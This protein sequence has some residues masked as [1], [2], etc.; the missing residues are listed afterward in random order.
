MA[1]SAGCYD[2]TA[3]AMKITAGASR[4][5]IDPI[6]LDNDNSQTHVSLRGN[7]LWKS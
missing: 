5:C 2:L 7:L 6:V 1:D 3:V 4:D